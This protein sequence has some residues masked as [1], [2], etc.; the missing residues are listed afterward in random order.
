M[1][2]RRFRAGASAS[3]AVAVACSL[4]LPAA[5]L[6]SKPHTTT[7]TS[8]PRAAAARPAAVR[9]SFFPASLSSA[10]AAAAP[11]KT[12]KLKARLVNHGRATH[13]ARFAVRLTKAGSRPVVVGHRAVALKPGASKAITISVALPKGLKK[14]SYALVGCL[15]KG[16]QGWL[17]CATAAR[18]VE[19]GT[20]SPAASISV[21]RAAV[22]AA[23]S[24]SSGAHTLSRA[25]DHVYVEMGN[26]GYTSVH[27]DVHLIYDVAG[28]ALLN[29]TYVDLT[30]QA[31]QCLTDFSL[32]FE[33]ANADPAGP[34]MAVSSIT[35]NGRP[36]TFRFAQP[37]Y[38]GDPNGQDDPDPNA[39]LTGQTNPIS[40][41]NP[42]APACAP[43]TTSASG[44][45]LQ[46]PAN[47]LVIAPAD[48]IPSGA[49]FDVVV[50]YA[51][52]PGVHVDGDGSTE[53]WFTGTDGSFVTT[54]P[55]GTMDWMPLNNHPSVKPTYDFYDT[56][57][58]GKTAIA[59]GELVSTADDASDPRIAGGTTTWHWHS[60]EHIANYLV[61]NSI[62]AY[63]LSSR[64]SSTGPN[65]GVVYYQA[66]SASIAATKKAT[67]KT[68]MDT[69]QDI[70]DFQTQFNGAFPFSTDGVIIGTPGASFEE[71][72][73]TKI[74]F[75]GSSISSGTF[76]H[77]NM[78]QWWGDNVSEGN[79]NLTFFKEGFAQLGEYLNNAKNVG[80]G[81]NVPGS[82][83]FETSLVNQFN[84]N[85]ASTSA[86]TGAP[87]NP[88]PSSLFSTS[89]TYRRPATA[90]IALRQI[91]GATPFN[92]ALQEIQATYGGRS[93]TEPQEEAVFHKYLPN[94]SAACSTKLDTFF[95]QW[96]DTAYPAGG[97]ANKPQ[98]TGPGLSGPGFYDA[99][100][101]CSSGTVP[102]TTATVS[103]AAVGG[104]YSGP[105]VTLSATDAGGPGVGTSYLSV[106][107]ADFV[108]YT[109]TPV[110]VAGDGTHTVRF[111]SVDTAG[112]QEPAG[113]LTFQEDST[114]P[115]TTAAVTPVPDGGQIASG[116]ATVTLSAT[117]A[118]GSG[119]AA[120]AYAVDGGDPIAWTGA[121]ITVSGAGGHTVAFSSVDVAGNHEATRSV[122]FVI[123][124]SGS[125]TVGG[126]VPSTL[127]LEVGA[128][129]ASLGTF[130]PGVAADY[131]TTIPVSVTSTGGNAA[132]TIADP[133]GVSTGHLVNGAF[134][135][136]SPLQAAA[137]AGSGTPSFGAVTGVASPLT[138][139]TYAAPV[140]RDP[141]TL[142][143]KQHVGA[144]DAL[145]T[146]RYAKTIVVTLS[147]TQP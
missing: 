101:G 124:A 58:L 54:E 52:R 65:A 59:N 92:R 16:T 10:P 142:W 123:D 94:Q 63:D 49:T 37:T 127:A 35:V 68:V 91:L 131:G 64:I 85:Y 137:T 89:F 43:T 18:H 112:N 30:Q 62:G 34:A 106:D 119:V 78:H 126:N 136:A 17:A 25:G 36:A 133:S 105:S 87:S 79:F 143:L 138:L 97:G 70:T 108:A 132:L 60:P 118:G 1:T 56:V 103:P 88:T 102:A 7:R 113:S 145:R 40:A 76:Y 4:A 46:C 147:T 80:G 100:G 8:A 141:V 53:G 22:A 93:I 120:T 19:V 114:A 75:A 14:G 24:C 27:S 86:W 66:Q 117:D 125:A 32:D 140:T 135:L 38:P 9:R 82:A 48:P 29:G 20:A 13:A 5:G 39:H 110:P 55:V 128:T 72:M 74:T 130:V 129:S 134:A 31:T 3:A 146:G 115:V 121:P 83:N 122:A 50:N 73:Q 42:N 95:T 47:K 41:T 111:Y 61:T 109:G 67:N 12:Y 71:E 144:T 81:G 57:P 11:G 84:T 26:G 2:G 44:N 104:W 15:P 96:F 23:E 116:P 90:Y 6:A 139:L 28:N 107:G 33:Q 69:Q 99:T 21:K 77:E 98:I 45:G 51:G